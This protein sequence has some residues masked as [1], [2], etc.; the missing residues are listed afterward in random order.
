M[1]L[2]ELENELKE[3]KAR[4][5]QLRHKMRQMR[6]SKYSPEVRKIMKSIGWITDDADTVIHRTTGNLNVR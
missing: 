6:F 5:D 2:A 3:L 4:Q 1:T